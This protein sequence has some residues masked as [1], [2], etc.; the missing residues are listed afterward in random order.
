MK[1]D[2]TSEWYEQR[3]NVRPCRKPLRKRLV[4]SIRGTSPSDALPCE[5]GL[6]FNIRFQCRTIRRVGIRRTRG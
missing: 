6:W 2:L 3:L 1:I 5:Y 4:A